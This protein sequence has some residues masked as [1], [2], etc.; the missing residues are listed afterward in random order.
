MFS[1]R[2]IITGTLLVVGIF[3]VF[4]T[5][6]D[7]TVTVWID[8]ADRSTVSVRINGGTIVTVPPGERREL[9]TPAGHAIFSIS[10]GSA[11]PRLES[12]FLE[13]TTDDRYRRT[14]LLNPDRR[15]YY[16]TADLEYGGRR[17]Q[18]II[19]LALNSGLLN[20]QQRRNVIYHRLRRGVRL[21]PMT[22]WHDISQTD[23]RFRKAPD[24]L[25]VTAGFDQITTLQSISRTQY[26]QLTK[27]T[28]KHAPQTSDC[29]RLCATTRDIIRTF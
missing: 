25:L 28:G 10:R 22:G 3:S 23:V 15:Q 11:P 4:A 17:R 26:C 24:Q 12:H 9:A 19:D 21:L 13:P 2:S 6:D 18:E 29:Q 20:D 14:Y 27:V 1:A 5:S 8:N 7:D 16:L